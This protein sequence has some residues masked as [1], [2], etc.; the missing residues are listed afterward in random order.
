MVT[1]H[2][3]GGIFMS[4]KIIFEARR[5]MVTHNVKD[6]AGRTSIDL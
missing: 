5:Q 6:F 4:T 3:N 2:R 1:D